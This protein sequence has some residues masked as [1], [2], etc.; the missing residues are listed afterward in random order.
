MSWNEPGGNKKDPWS[1]RDNQP[2][3]PNEIDEMIRSLQDRLGKLFGGGDGGDN[4]FGASGAGFGLLAAAGIGVWA[5]TGIY[6]VDEGNRGVVTRFGKY[7]ETTM[8][9]P[10]GISRRPSRASIPS[11]WKISAPWK[12]VTVPA[13]DAS[14]RPAPCRKKP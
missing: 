11:M 2:G 13:A 6:I 5:L 3:K 9:G 14:N 10:I 4:K 1:G 12:W 7:L 8:P